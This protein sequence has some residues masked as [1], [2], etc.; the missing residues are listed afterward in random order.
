MASSLKTQLYLACTAYVDERIEGIQKAMD[1]AQQAANAE[2]KSTA[3]DKHDTSR[4]MM[5]QEKENMARQMAEALK[6]KNALAQINPDHQA[7]EIGPGS[8][9]ETNAGTYFLAIGIGKLDVEGK[10]YFV[11][12]AASPI[13][14]QMLG[15]KAGG[16]FT[17]NGR[18]F[19]V[20][21]VS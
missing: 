20:K 8:L 2:T 17:F 7:N 9:V 16:S 19:Q 5:H 18:N 1:E 11:L 15:L 13:G 10:P 6:L 14:Q 3:G 21:A 4:A 12:S